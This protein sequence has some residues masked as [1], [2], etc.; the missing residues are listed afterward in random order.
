ML[1][2]LDYV[3]PHLAQRIHKLEEELKRSKESKTEITNNKR[4]MTSTKDK[5]LNYQR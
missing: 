4:L 1:K 5:L 2:T 3:D